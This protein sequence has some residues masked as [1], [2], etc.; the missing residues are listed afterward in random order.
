MLGGGGNGLRW[1]RYRFLKNEVNRSRSRPHILL[2]RLSP[3]SSLGGTVGAVAGTGAGAGAG[4]GDVAAEGAAAEAEVM[5]KGGA[6]AV[7][8][9]SFFLRME[10]KTRMELPPSDFFLVGLLCVASSFLTSGTASASAA[11][12][13]PAGSGF[14]RS[15]S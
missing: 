7:S 5:G 8:A 6:D 4:G 15:S 2:L 12:L 10:P 9:L 14:L 13:G 11:G 3:S 1:V